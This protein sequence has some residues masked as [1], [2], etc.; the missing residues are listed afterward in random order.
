MNEKI[1]QINEVIKFYLDS[2]KIKTFRF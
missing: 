1:H 2:K